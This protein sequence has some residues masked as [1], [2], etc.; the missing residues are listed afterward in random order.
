MKTLQQEF[1][2]VSASVPHEHAQTIR[3]AAR[4]GLSSNSTQFPSLD[5]LIFTESASLHLARYGGLCLPHGD[6]SQ[7]KS[8]TLIG[9]VLRNPFLNC[10]Q[11]IF[12]TTFSGLIDLDI[13]ALEFPEGP[14]VQ[15]INEYHEHDE[16]A[17]RTAICIERLLASIYFS[18]IQSMKMGFL[19]VTSKIVHRMLDMSSLD[20]LKSLNIIGVNNSEFYNENM[21]FRE[22]DTD[23]EHK[24][25][26][27]W[28]S[29][30]L[31]LGG[32]L[33]LNYPSKYCDICEVHCMSFSDDQDCS[34]GCLELLKHP[35]LRASLEHLQLG[36]YVDIRKE[37][38]E[39]Y[40]CGDED[41]NED[42][43]VN[44]DEEEG[45]TKVTD[46]HDYLDYTYI[47][48]ANSLSYYKK[49]ISLH[50][51]CFRTEAVNIV[52]KHIVDNPPPNLS[53][54]TIMTT[55]DLKDSLFTNLHHKQ[56]TIDHWFKPRNNFVRKMMAFVYTNYNNPLI[57]ENVYREEV[58]RW[59]K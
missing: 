52:V 39:E 32:N 41:K 31:K 40:W 44:D 21:A 48:W 23:K 57:S 30:I 49:L 45:V 12:C 28:P 10:D 9:R 27:M 50:I 34:I 19:Q 58:K 46:G 22:I 55:P 11:N 25:Y 3:Y 20:K 18:Q 16:F 42:D 4:S 7:I 33:Y 1:L 35:K 38:I 47:R 17:T 15:A 56:K 36:C 43:D 14:Y 8:L 6:M 51:K 59:S 26:G 24:E 2:Q 37:E 53:I 29:Q 5:R 54:I 13:S